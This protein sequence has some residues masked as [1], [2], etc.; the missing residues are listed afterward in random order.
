M[1]FLLFRIGAGQQSAVGDR[2]NLSGTAHSAYS[3]GG[4][5]TDSYSLSGTANDAYSLSGE[6]LSDDT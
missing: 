5:A 2:Y 3:L 4:T 6:T 1:L